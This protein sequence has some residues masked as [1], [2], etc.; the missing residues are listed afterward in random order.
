[1]GWRENT[2]QNGFGREQRRNPY[3]GYGRRGGGRG[4]ARGGMFGRGREWVEAERRQAERQQA[5]RRGREE[6]QNG[7]AEQKG[8]EKK[9]ENEED[10]DSFKSAQLL[11]FLLNR[12]TTDVRDVCK[13]AQEV[14]E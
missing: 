5:R 1:M 12:C 8:D 3:S 10:G 4:G 14:H 11:D 6:P 7:D 13:R 9:D 2:A